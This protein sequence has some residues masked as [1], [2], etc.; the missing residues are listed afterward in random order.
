MIYFLTIEF[1]HK[2]FLFDLLL[3]LFREAWSNYPYYQEKLKSFSFS[4]AIASQSL[5]LGLW[6]MLDYGVCYRISGI[7]IIIPITNR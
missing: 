2:L 6:G 7:E 1:L 4:N 3:A 5:P